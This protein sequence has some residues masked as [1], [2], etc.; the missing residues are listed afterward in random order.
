ML[1]VPLPEKEI[2]P[3]LRDNDLSL[4]A[5]NGP[6]LCVVSGPAEQINNLSH[7]LAEHGV[8]CKTLHTS[9]AFHSAMMDPI[10]DAFRD[11]L[12]KI[13]FNS[14]QIPYVSNVTGK[15]ITEEEATDPDYWL[16]HLRQTVRFNDGLDELF[17]VPHQLFIE[18]GPGKALSTL[19]QRHPAK[20]A[21]LLVDRF[22]APR[23][24]DAV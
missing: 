18:V 6:A 10:L 15:W 24:G 9:H 11:E 12:E 13:D 1:S 22:A 14:P 20:P 21:K 8:D 2:L 5:V 19:A 7:Y 17:K 23:S 4:A 3:L 16:T